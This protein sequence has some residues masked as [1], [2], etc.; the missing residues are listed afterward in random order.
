MTSKNYNVQIVSSVEASPFAYIDLYLSNRDEFWG[1]VA[2]LKRIWQE[3]NGF[4]YLCYAV[5]K[6]SNF[7]E[8][9]IEDY[10]YPKK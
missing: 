8:L 3:A 2:E 1:V 4:T 6:G 5:D 7:E 9:F 10:L